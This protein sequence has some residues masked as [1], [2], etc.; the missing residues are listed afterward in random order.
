ME[1]LSLLQPPN[2]NQPSGDLSDHRSTLHIS[3]LTDAGPSPAECNCTSK[4]NGFDLAAYRELNKF[5]YKSIRENLGCSPT[6]LQPKP[7]HRSDRKAGVAYKTFLPHRTPEKGMKM[8]FRFTPEET[9]CKK[10]NPFGTSLYNH[11]SSFPQM[12]KLRRIFCSNVS[13]R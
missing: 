2:E 5:R 13:R 12:I 1:S 4:Y 8:S 9:S 7:R 3:H 11:F 6:Q 10:Q